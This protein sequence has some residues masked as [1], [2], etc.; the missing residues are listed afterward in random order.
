MRPAFGVTLLAATLLGCSILDPYDTL[1]R[2]AEPGQPTGPRVAIC[3]NTFATNLVAVRA[4]A[5]QEC[6]ADT[7]PE[8]VDTDWYLQACPVL[9]PARATFVC[10][11]KK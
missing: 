7:V 10:L 11:P 2:A 5:Q 1:P 4:R 8:A 6:P 3:Y 9:L